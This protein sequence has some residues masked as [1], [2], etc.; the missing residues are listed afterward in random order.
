MLAMVKLL[1]E[2]GALVDACSPRIA[3]TTDYYG[4]PD[5]G[6]TALRSSLL[7]GQLKVIRSLIDLGASASIPDRN[8]RLIDYYL[9]Q[10]TRYNS[11]TRIQLKNWFEA[12]RKTPPPKDR[13]KAAF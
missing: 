13:K 11:T 1:L 7:L 12:A 9:E 3:D 4:V 5:R 2:H 8:G 10:S 6:Y